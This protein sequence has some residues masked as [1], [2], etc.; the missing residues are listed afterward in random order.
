MT[1]VMPITLKKIVNITNKMVKRDGLACASTIGTSFGVVFMGI[2]L[3][4]Y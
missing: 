4:L 1:M 3:V 2:L